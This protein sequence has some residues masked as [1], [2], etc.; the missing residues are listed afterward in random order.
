MLVAPR[1]VLEWSGH[2]AVRTCTSLIICGRDDAV[3]TNYRA[4]CDVRIVWGGDATVAVMRAMPIPPHAVELCFPDHWSLAVLSQR[5]FLAP[6]PEERG[7]LT[8]R[9]RN[10]TRQMD[11]GVCSSPQLVSWL[12]DGGD[13]AC[14]A[15]W[16]EVV[17]AKVVERYPFGPFQMTHK[18]KRLCLCIITT[19]QPSVVV[20]ECYQNNLLYVAQLAGL[21]GSLSS[22]AGGF[23]LFSEMAL[24]S[25]EVLV[26]PLPPKM[27]TLVY[28]GLEPV[29]VAA[30]LARTGV[31]DADRVV[32]L[33][34]A[35]EMDTA[36]GGRGLIVALFCTI[37]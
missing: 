22:L 28:G 36:W 17:T 26:L 12:E 31:Q 14:R 30:L 35:L 29:E 20:V 7:A 21:S 37:R 24:P 10:D 19:E 9:F 6:T 23:R 15:R 25:L 1:R 16:W 8:H 2:A 32:S 4:R 33:E 13:L 11:Q 3:V 18:L 5:A 27:Q 34:Q